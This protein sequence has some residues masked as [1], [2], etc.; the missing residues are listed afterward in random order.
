MPEIP[1]PARLRNCRRAFGSNSGRGRARLDSGARRRHFGSQRFPPPS[2]VVCIGS[3]RR[4]G[5]RTVLPVL[6]MTGGAGLTGC[7]VAPERPV[8]AERV[9][10][11]PPE[12][13]AQVVAY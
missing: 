7:V 9:E 6:L 1:A 13:V 3:L 12:Q 2:V 11:P 4:L 8:V 10:A 5:M